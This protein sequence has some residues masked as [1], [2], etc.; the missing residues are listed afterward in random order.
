VTV[1]VAAVL[2]GIL[3]QILRAVAVVLVD[4]L[5]PAVSVVAL[6]LQAQTGELL[7][8]APVVVAVV[9]ATAVLRQRAVLRHREVVLAY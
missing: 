2:A 4:M 7:Q 5:V 8:Q 3:V 9:V 6:T 1:E